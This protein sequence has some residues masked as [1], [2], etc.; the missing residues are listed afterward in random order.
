LEPVAAAWPEANR[1]FHTDYRWKGSD[2]AYSIDLGHGR[3]LW[4]FGDA[5]IASKKSS[6]HQKRSKVFIRNCVA[7]QNGYDPIVATMEYFWG[8]RGMKPASFFSDINKFWYWPLDGVMVDSRL[9]IFLSKVGSAKTGLGFEARGYECRIV[10]NPEDNPDKWDIRN[11]QLPDVPWCETIGSAVEIFEDSLYSFCCNR[12]HAI[13]LARWSLES[14]RA[15]LLDNPE[16]WCGD[17]IGWVK[18]RSL[19][20]RFVATLFKNGMTEFSVWRDT[21]AGQFLLVQ[22]EGFGQAQLILRRANYLIGPWTEP[23]VIFAPPENSIPDIMIYAAKAHPYLQSN[24]IA[25]TYATNGSERSFKSDSSIYY[26]RFV[27]LTLRSSIINIP[28][29]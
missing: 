26:P 10:E 2:A 24:G 19:N 20:G 8:L 11:I 16:W 22:T 1:I 23:E 15:G 13:S 5:L 9:L 3:V 7:I 29:K 21:L 18:H 4:F 28:A 25:L 12:D 14:V 17:G 6:L 27:R